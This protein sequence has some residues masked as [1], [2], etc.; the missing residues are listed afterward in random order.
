MIHSSSFEN[1][2]ALK[3]VAE[4]R[5]RLDA[6]QVAKAQES[7]NRARKAVKSPLIELEELEVLALSG[8]WADLANKAKVRS[9]L[10]ARPAPF[11]AWA[12]IAIVYDNA[13]I[14]EAEDFL[15]HAVSIAPDDLYVPI[16]RALVCFAGGHF[17]D[18]EKW[19]TQ[20]GVGPL[21]RSASA[22]RAQLWADIY[23][24]NNNA[25]MNRFWGRRAV[26][27]D[28]GGRFAVSRLRHWEFAPYTYET[29]ALDYPNI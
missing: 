29:S 14:S 5:E 23:R 10:A 17:P 6:G 11:F 16:A 9:A 4:I 18:A 12:A 13:D 27:L 26:A 24:R 8:A 20:I 22:M 19:L 7:V 2:M 21:P 28:P 15:R 25:E 1:Y 3:Y